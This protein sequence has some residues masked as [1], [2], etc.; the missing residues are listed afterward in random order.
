MVF[1]AA[2][3]SYQVEF[4]NSDYPG[5]KCEK[6]EKMSCRNN[7]SVKKMFKNHPENEY[8]HLEVI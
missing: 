6:S 5:L 3:V 7:Q 1:D 2:R 8:S 4:L